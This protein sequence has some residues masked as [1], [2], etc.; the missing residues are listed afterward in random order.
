[1]NKDTEESIAALTPQDIEK[2]IEERKNGLYTN[3]NY[4]NNLLNVVGGKAPFCQISKLTN[5]RELKSM[6]I[7]HGNANLYITLSPDDTKHPLAYKFCMDD[8]NNFSFASK[9]LD[10]RQFRA[11]QTSKNPVGISLFFYNLVKIILDHLFG[12]KNDEKLGLF[13]KIKAHYGMVETQARGTL[14]V[15]LLLWIHGSPSPLDLYNEL[16]QNDALKEAML[17]YLTKII[18]TGD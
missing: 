15:H 18:Y 13:G 1:M 11:M 10:D 3:S 9:E 6:I 5:R 7:F 2:A 14:H 8:P 16:Q 12:W 17:S 4:L